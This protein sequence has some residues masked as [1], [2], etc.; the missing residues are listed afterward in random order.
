MAAGACSSLFHS[1][2]LPQWYGASYWGERCCL[3]RLVARVLLGR[4]LHRERL[5]EQR[6]APT[7]HPG[8]TFSVDRDRCCVRRHAHLRRRAVPVLT[9]ASISDHRPLTPS[10][11]TRTDQRRRSVDTTTSLNSALTV[12]DRPTPAPSWSTLTRTECP[13]RRAYTTPIGRYGRWSVAAS[14]WR[15]ATDR[16]LHAGPGC[17]SRVSC[18]VL[19]APGGRSDARPWGQ[20]RATA[21]GRGPVRDRGGRW[22][23]PRGRGRAG[24]GR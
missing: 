3:R 1:S 7:K 11:P 19:D 5:D 16:R 22:L 15:P 20:S 24:R 23:V 6:R 21:G 12:P 2:E 13:I 9:A 14:W 17:R 18:C 10:T 4:R 8:S